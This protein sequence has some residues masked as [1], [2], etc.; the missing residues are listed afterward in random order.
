MLTIVLFSSKGKLFKFVLVTATPVVS[1]RSFSGSCFQVQHVRAFFS[2]HK[3]AV[4]VF[5]IS[6]LSFINAFARAFCPALKEQFGVLQS[7]S[8]AL[9]FTS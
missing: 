5:R 2:A 1:M 3:S 6:E 4:I 7:L 8:L 9:L